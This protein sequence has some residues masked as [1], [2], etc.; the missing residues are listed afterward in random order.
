MS[1]V[2]TIKG[3]DVRLEVRHSWPG[4][5]RARPGDVVCVVGFSGSFE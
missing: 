2:G 1:E 5:S 3:Q 4:A